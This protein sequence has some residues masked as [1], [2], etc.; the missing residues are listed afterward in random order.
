[1][2]DATEDVE[3]DLAADEQERARR[4]AVIRCTAGNINTAAVL[5]SIPSFQLCII[6]FF[7]FLK[8]C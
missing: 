3:L 6:R 2:A 5:S 1:M 4:S 8:T 7:G